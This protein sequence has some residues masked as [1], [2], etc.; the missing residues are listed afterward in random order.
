M[1]LLAEVGQFRRMG[2]N[3]GKVGAE[4]GHFWAGGGWPRRWIQLRRDFSLAV[5]KAALHRV[6][7]FAA[8]KLQVQIK[9]VP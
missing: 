2:D 7:M 9:I 6:L 3:V 8:T 4:R 5:A 1:F